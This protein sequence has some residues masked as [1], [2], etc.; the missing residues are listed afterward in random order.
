MWLGF[1]LEHATA[2]T[3]C[4]I[5]SV[6]RVAATATKLPHGY[7]YILCMYKI[8]IQLYIP[9]INIFVYR[10][11]CVLVTHFTIF[12]EFLKLLLPLPAPAAIAAPAAA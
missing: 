1:P 4:A 7:I 3:Q 5:V 11:I 8:C 9:H 10:N 12:G 2:K 6:K